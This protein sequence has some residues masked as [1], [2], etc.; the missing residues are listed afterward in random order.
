MIFRLEFIAEEAKEN[1][2]KLPV[3]NA[4]DL[5][6]WLQEQ[7]SQAI[8]KNGNKVGQGQNWSIFDFCNQFLQTRSQLEKATIDIC[9]RLYLENVVYAE[10]RFCP[11]LHTSLGLSAE[12]ALQA[13][14]A[15]NSVRNTNYLPI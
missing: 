14:V 9:R 11:T 5:R 12:E 15:G 3:E 8:F 1:G 2:I 10:I 4:K 13:V 7:K 6:K